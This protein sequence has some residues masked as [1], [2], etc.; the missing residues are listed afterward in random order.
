MQDAATRQGY[1]LA[2]LLK[3][4]HSFRKTFLE[5]TT[6]LDQSQSRKVSV[7]QRS[8]IAWYEARIRSRHPYV[9][10][11]WLYLQTAALHYFEGEVDPTTTDQLLAA[12]A[13]VQ[14]PKDFLPA[15]VQ[16]NDEQITMHRLLQELGSSC[17][18][19]LLLSYYHRIGDGRLAEILDLS[20]RQ[21]A[22]ERRRRCLLMVREGWTSAGPI[23]PGKTTTSGQRTSRFRVCSRADHRNRYRRRSWQ[24]GDCTGGKNSLA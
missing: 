6:D 5:W 4:Y 24:P 17:R 14:D 10:D 20:G 3:H 7:Y 19:L 21:D 15:G 8:L 16:L 11:V 2:E 23:L 1:H 22:A 12:V 18:E 9:G 13:P